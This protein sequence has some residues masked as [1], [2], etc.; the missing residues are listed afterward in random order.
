MTEIGDSSPLM[1]KLIDIRRFLNEEL[2][3]CREIKIFMK[4]NEEK[5]SSDESENDDEFLDVEDKEGQI[6]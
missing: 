2:Q 5:E 3:K 1:R 6:L 4:Q